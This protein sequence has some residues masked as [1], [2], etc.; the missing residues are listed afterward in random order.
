MVGAGIAVIFGQVIS[1]AIAPVFEWQLIAVSTRAA[2]HTLPGL[3]FI[4][5]AMMR[6]E[7]NSL[8]TAA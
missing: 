5:Y 3:I 2:L 4:A 6:T 7:S 8:P 1:I